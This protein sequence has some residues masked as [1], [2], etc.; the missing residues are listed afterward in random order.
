MIVLGMQLAAIS[1]KNIEKEKMI[2]PLIIKLIISPL[3]ALVFVMLLP[4]GDIIGK[5][6]ILMAAMPSAANTTMYALQFNTQPEFVSSVNFCQYDYKHCLYSISVIF[7][8]KFIILRKILKY[9][10]NHCIFVLQ[11]HVN[12]TISAYY[13]FI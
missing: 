4:V 6:I 1:L 12:V 9:S 3:L 2:Y 10:K 13:K 7:Y 11:T 5:I 8:T